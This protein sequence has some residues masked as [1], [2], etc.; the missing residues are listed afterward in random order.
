MK[1][2]LFD[3]DNT[4]LKGDSDHAWG[5]FLVNHNWVDKIV[6]RQK[7]DQFLRDYEA[8]KLDAVAYLQF[9]L[10]LLTR[11]NPEQLAQMHRQFMQESI[12]PMVLPKGLALLDQHRRAGDTLII[13][14]ATN[15]FVTGPIAAYLGVDY[16]L[17]TRAQ[18]NPQG[19][20]TGE[21][22]GPPC[23]QG[24]KIKHLQQWLQGRDVNWA[25]TY[26]YSDSHNDLPLLQ[27]VGH[28]VAVD[29]DPILKDYAATQSWQQISL[30]T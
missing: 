19:C 29:A 27:H 16:L 28:P 4:L 24:G 18:R 21:I 6:Y 9:T 25:A 5:E 13:I 23:F 1:L 11:F 26:F 17:A 8:G 2:A 14:T 22:V 12:I 30:R 20:Y 10:Q 3:L 7:N 15:D